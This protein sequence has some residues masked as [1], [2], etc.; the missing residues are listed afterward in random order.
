MAAADGTT[1]IDITI[2]HYISFELC[3]LI[4]LMW[5]GEDDCRVL[6]VE[7]H[8]LFVALVETILGIRFSI[9]TLFVADRR[10]VQIFEPDLCTILVLGRQ[11]ADH[12]VDSCKYLIYGVYRR[13]SAVDRT[14]W[15]IVEE[16]ID[17]ATTS[18]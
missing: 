6:L 1:P 4:V 8:I 2:N 15:C 11:I 16:H 12:V 17:F 5:I 13:R 18:S 10:L 3:I 14:P 7:S 9:V